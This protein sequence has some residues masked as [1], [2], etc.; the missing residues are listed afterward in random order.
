MTQKEWGKY[1]FYEIL[2]VRPTD[3]LEV[4]RRNYKRLAVEYHPD[5]HPENKPYYTAQFELL[6][7]GYKILS[8]PKLRGL[9][10][11]IR[12]KKL[13][14]MDLALERRRT[15]T[16]APGMI[17]L[18][19]SGPAPSTEKVAAMTPAEIERE[20]QKRRSEVIKVEQDE[21]LKKY[22]HDTFM[23]IFSENIESAPEVTSSE[24]IAWNHINSG[25]LQCYD[26]TTGNCAVAT[27]YSS[28]DEAFSLQR[29]P[30]QEMS[31]KDRLQHYNKVTAEL[32][33]QI[34]TRSLEEV[35]RQLKSK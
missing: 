5:K 12:K 3:S 35:M 1:N 18:E 26:A 32:E 14:V 19:K 25:E 28:I 33:A 8:N 10:D 11:E 20:L 7:N 24:I 21:R 34:P 22:N 17:P 2:Q 4:L 23:K 6:V 31:V 29:I 13:E 16:A 9:Y 27:S 15:H 30:Y